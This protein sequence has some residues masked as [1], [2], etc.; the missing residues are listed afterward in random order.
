VAD[1]RQVRPFSAGLVAGLLV[2]AAA[3]AGAVAWGQHHRHPSPATPA[4]AADTA[5][6]VVPGT[7]VRLDADHRA[8]TFLPL[9]AQPR[10]GRTLTAQHAYNALVQTPTKL[11]PIPATVR[12]YYGVLDDPSTA[13]VTVDRRVWAFAVEARCLR[14]A[15]PSL[16][17]TPTSLHPRRCRIWE[18]VD[19]RTG[20]ALGVIEQ[21]VLP[22]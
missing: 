22:D 13:P 14:T 19:A 8:A 6:P 1:H 7:V 18:F 17:G 11:N 20:H 2:L 12:A 15:R 9:G 16:T 10:D 5:P 3:T 4:L 21:Q